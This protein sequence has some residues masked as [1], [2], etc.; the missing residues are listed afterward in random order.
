MHVVY[1]VGMELAA[2]LATAGITQAAFARR[3]GTA[4]SVISRLSRGTI[5]PGLQLAIRIE[6]E[7]A[8]AVPVEAWAETGDAA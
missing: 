7:T 8:G 4:Q 3:V 6:Q 1:S 5:K 2:H